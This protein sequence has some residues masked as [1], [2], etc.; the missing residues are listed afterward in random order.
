MRSLYGRIFL[1]LWA[2]MVLIVAGSI[3]LTW[4]VLTERTEEIPRV[5]GELMRGA[6]AALS[7]GGRP[8]LTAWLRLGREAVPDLRVLVV[9]GSGH[10]LLGRELP[11]GVERL[12]REPS[13]GLVSYSGLGII[14]ARPLPQLVAGDGQSY[15]ILI[16]PRRPVPGPLGVLLLAFAVTGGAGWLLT[17]SIPRPVRALGAAARVLAEGDLNARI[18]RRVTARR[19]EFG[20]LARMRVG[21]GLAR[22]P[23]GATSAANSTDSRPKSNGST[24]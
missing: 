1:S 5:S 12:L 24:G 21:L 17:R 19:D 16:Q 15:G 4:L 6:A 18:E 9:D 7:Q 23:G 10:E 3:G 14:P 8:A 22:Q 13:S 2:V 20:T 11:S